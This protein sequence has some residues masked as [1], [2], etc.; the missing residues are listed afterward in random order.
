LHPFFSRDIRQRVTYQNILP[1]EYTLA[2]PYYHLFLCTGSTCEQQGAEELLQTLQRRLRHNGLLKKVRV[3]LCRC[4]GQ[5]GNG[6]NMVI[7]PEG[8]WYGSL[9]ESEIEQIVHEHLIGGEAV[10]GLVQIPVE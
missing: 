2:S 6:P 10:Q 3:T 5:C 7:Y 1:K 9:G 8:V 4:L